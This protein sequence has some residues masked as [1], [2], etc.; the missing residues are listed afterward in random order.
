MYD[1][2]IEIM[3]HR[4]ILHDDSLGVS[5]ALNE[6]AYGKGLVVTGKHHIFVASPSN[7]ARLH[8]IAAQHLYMHPLATYSLPNASYENFSTSVRQSWSAL[9]DSL[10]MNVHLLTFDQLNF[11]EY[12]V[13][14]EHYFE[15][16]EDDAYSKSV[17]VDL[18]IIFNSIGPI[19]EIVELTL[20]ANLPLSE[21][22][23][24]DWMTKDSTSFTPDGYGRW[25]FDSLS[26]FQSTSFSLPFFQI[27]NHQLLQQTSLSIPCKFEHFE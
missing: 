23:R 24:L 17:T 12:L 11:K 27:R 2:S 26:F 1:G 5:E 18:Q 19:T 20:N 22:H 10:P 25:R 7:S 15:L 21:L 16:N 4:R 6:T 9:T 8:R 14:V 3:V 13:R